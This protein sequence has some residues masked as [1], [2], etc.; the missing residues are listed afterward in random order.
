MF[1]STSRRN[2][3][4]FDFGQDPWS[5]TVYLNGHYYEVSLRQGKPDQPICEFDNQRRCIYVNWGHPVKG[6]MDDRDLSQVSHP[7][8]TRALR[9]PK[10]RECD[11]D[12]GL[13]HDRLSGGVVV[14]R[15]IKIL[16]PI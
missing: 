16:R 14:A 4:A 9:G 15:L 5:T 10:R 3:V 1:R 13:K 2:R 6:H 12:V 7:P 11:D 8:P